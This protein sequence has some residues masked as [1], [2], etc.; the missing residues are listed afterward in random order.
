MVVR[1][2]AALCVAAILFAFSMSSS[3]VIKS[4]NVKSASVKSGGVV[5]GAAAD[6]PFAQS[7]TQLWPV[8]STV[9]EHKQNKENA[10]VRS[11]T[12]LGTAST[13][14]PYRPG[15]RS[16]GTETASGEQYDP[17]AWTAAIQIDLREMFGGVRYG[18]DYLPSYALVAKNDKQA[19]VKINDVGPLEPGRVIDFNEQTMRYFDPSLELGLIALVEVTPLRGIDW[20]PG[21]I[22]DN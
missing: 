19:I 13:Y 20:L 7:F 18:K 5:L 10:V 17:G 8:H 11:V 21:P 22:A 12:L 4:A 3:S 6:E 9:M 1:L 2:G 15:Y 16:G 14:N